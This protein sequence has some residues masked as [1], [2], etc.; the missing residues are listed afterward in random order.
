MD[1][2]SDLAVPVVSGLL[3]V[4]GQA[5]TNRANK[6]I[7]REQMRFQERMS[8]TAAQRAV[9]DYKAAG[10]NPALAYD[11]GASS[12]S[13][14]SATLGNAMEAG[15]SSALRAREAAQT[16]RQAA[17][18]HRENLRLTRAQTIKTATEAEESGARQ[19]LLD[20]DWISKVRDNQYATI[21]QPIQLRLQ[22]AQALMQELLLPGARNTADLERRMGQ[23]TPGFGATALRML[24][25]GV[26]TVRR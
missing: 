20:Q 3:G 16:L 17:E 23:L 6:Q 22:A 9:A 24:Y 18:L 12:P 4:G 21:A 19:K 26:K 2:I 1:I 11:R 7:A 15:V 5:Q 10:L 14:A 8:N 25:E 13:G